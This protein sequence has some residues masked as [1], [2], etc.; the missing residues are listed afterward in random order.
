MVC[1]VKRTNY[2]TLPGAWQRVRPLRAS[3]EIVRQFRHA[4]FEER[5]RAGDLLGS[6]QQ[7]ATSFGV[8]RTT[9]RDALR[10]LEATGL[11]EIRTGASG[12]VRVAHGDPRK[13]ADA[14]AVQLKL[15]G[16]NPRD[17]LAAQMGLEWAAAELAATNATQAD[18]R[19]LECL[20]GQAAAVVDDQGPAFTD[21]SSAFH[22]AIARA[23][24]NWAIETGLRAIRELLRQMLVQDIQP[25]RARRVLR[26]HREIHAAIRAGDADLAAHLMR[27]H[28]R[29]MRDASQ[30]AG[31]HRLKGAST[32][33]AQ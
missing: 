21:A 10:S 6:E 31:S 14:L 7:L 1:S 33:A 12:G 15:V 28:V 8:S 24:H 27:A 32:D 19:E 17:A 29:A 5:L 11:V 30:S 3:D 22:D 4:L 13:F 2:M 16:L 25:A 9:M 26:T 20:L 18:L 23:A